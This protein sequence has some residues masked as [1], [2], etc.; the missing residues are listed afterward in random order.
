MGSSEEFLITFP[1]YLLLHER[2][3]VYNKKGKAT[4]YA[5]PFVF[6]A[7]ESDK[8]EK[9]LP[10]FTDKDLAISFIDVSDD[11]ECACILVS[12]AH[13]LI[14]FLDVAKDKSPFVVF[15]PVKPKGWSKQVWPTDY[16]I[17]QVKKGDGL[18]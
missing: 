17:T 2:C 7:L 9:S 5:Q 1:C 4:G 14:A 18:R 12:N 15:D 13:E 11:L 8:G 6:V 3:I 10:V 16:V